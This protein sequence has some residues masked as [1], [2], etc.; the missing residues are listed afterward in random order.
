MGVPRRGR[1]GRGV[2][3]DARAH[4]GDRAVPGVGSG[5]LALLQAGHAPAGP[6]L[7]GVL[8]ELSVLPGAVT[9]VLDDYHR[10]N[11]SAVRPGMTY[12]IDHL[13][14]QLRLVVST[15]ADRASPWPAC[16]PAAS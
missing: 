1:P 10:A 5:A 2:V 8:N 16:A 4:R 13:P 3:L 6:V 12:M 9:L 7:A 14:P 11:G 15:R